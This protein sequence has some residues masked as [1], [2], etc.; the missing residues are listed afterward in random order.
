MKFDIRVFFFKYNEKFKVLLNSDKNNVYITWRFMYIL[1]QYFGEIF[2]EEEM[3]ETVVVETI[4]QSIHF[5]PQMSCCLWN[6]V[7]KYGEARQAT[8]DNVIRRVRLAWW[9]KKARIQYTINI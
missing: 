6:N 4:K 1:W 8:D 5:F 9:V 7:E 2:S 3:F